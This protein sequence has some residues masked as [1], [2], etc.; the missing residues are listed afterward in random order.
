MPKRLSPTTI[1]H[2]L[3][4][5]VVFVWGATFVLI[6]D[7]LADA[8][9][10][11][12]NLLR[13][14]LAFIALAIVNHR[15]LRHINRR[16]RHLRSRRRPLPRSGLPV[17]DRRARAHNAGEVRLH[18]WPGRRLR[19]TPHNRP[20]PQTCQRR[21]SPLDHSS[22]STTRLLR[23]SPS[24]HSRRNLLRKPLRQHRLRR[25]PHPR[26]RHRLRRPPPRPRPHLAQGPHRSTR[27][28]PDRRSNPLHGHHPSLGRTTPRINNPPPS[29]ST[30]DHQPLSHCRCFHHPKLGSTTPPANPHSDP[31][32]PRTRLRLPNLIPHPA[33]TSC[34]SLSSRGSPYPRRNRR[35]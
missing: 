2:L 3:L 32:H 20:R 18:H 19:P 6:K 35:D 8:S 33:R 31:P 26:L 30:S 4:L 22:R 17:P 5:A 29:H 10:L 14:S 34:P 16:R 28:P 15:H 7:A 24:N 12:F 23:P 1:A 13:M 11:L 21:A 27:H 25:P 9:P